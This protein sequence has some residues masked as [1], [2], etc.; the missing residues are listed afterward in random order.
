MEAIYNLGLVNL[1]MEM[2]GEALQAFEKLHQIVPNN[3]EGIF[4]IAALHEARGQLDVAL[5]WYNILVTRV[6]SDPGVLLRM[7]QLCSRSDD[8]A[9]AFHFHL[10]SYRHYPVSLDVISWLG[11]WYVKSEMRA[12]ASFLS[13]D[14]F[15][16]KRF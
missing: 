12:S 11:V 6:P 9:Q 2:W 4:Q 8:E 1:K 16:L 13:P 7:G 5:K 14:C 15:F 3:A 10:E